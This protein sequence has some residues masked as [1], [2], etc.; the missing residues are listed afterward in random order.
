[1]HKFYLTKIDH[2]EGYL[3]HDD[4]YHLLKVLR[5][6][7]GDQFIGIYASQKYL[8]KIINC[9]P[10]SITV[11]QQFNEDTTNPFN[12]N[13]YLASVKPAAM[14]LAI[15]KA[16]EL[17]VHHFYI[18]NSQ[19]SQGNIVHNLARYEK[20]I[21]VAS[22][23]ANRNHLMQISYLAEISD[24]KTSLEGNELNLIADFHEPSSGLTPL[25]CN[26]TTKR[27]GLIVGP[28][29]GFSEND[30]SALKTPNS[31]I[32]NLTKTI[33]RAETAVLYLVSIVSDL[34]LRRA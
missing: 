16:C 7:V 13:V 10:L 9:K 17:N 14:E 19:W 1:M 24:L 2:A 25:I 11:M 5:Q 26:P 28:E 32:I 12:L 22:Q 30:I 27:I 6:Q 20:L 31:H 34:K 23:Q 29:A 15:V 8:C 3:N 21:K 4:E 18:F 33:L